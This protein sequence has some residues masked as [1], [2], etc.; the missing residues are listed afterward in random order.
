MKNKVAIIGSYLPRKCGIATFSSDLRQH[1][2]EDETD[3][4]VIAMN[5][6]ETGYTYPSEVKFQIRQNII[7]D[8]ISAADFINSN[9]LDAVYLQHEYGIY[10][11]EYGR[12]VLQLLKR[13]NVPIFTTLHT[14][15][16]TPS[17]EQKEIMQ[18]IA[19]HSSK[20]I[21][22]SERGKKMLKEIYDVE[23]EKIEI[24]GHGIH[25]IKKFK[26]KCYKKELGIEGKKVLLTFGLLSKNKGIETVIES[27]PKIME[28]HPD[29]IYIVL[30]ASHPHVVKNEGEDY[31][32]SLIMLTNKLKLE[33]NIIFIDRFVSNEELFSFLQSS[34][35][36]VIPY[37]SKK[38]ITSGTLVYAMGAC[39]A[40]VSTP[41]WH[42]EEALTDERGIFFDF[43][44]SE[45][46]SAIVTDLLSDEEKLK[47]YQ[48][49]ACEYS[50]QFLWENI[51]K[52]YISLIQQTEPQNAKFYKIPELNEKSPVFPELNLNHL[53]NLTDDTGIL[54]HARFHI[55]NRN[56]GYCIDDNARALF[57]TMLLKKKLG[58]N[59]KVNHIC[60]T[61]LSFIDHAY[62]PEAGRFRNFMSYER[63][64][65]ETEGSEDSQGRT[66]WALGAVLAHTYN[67]NILG[68]VE[69][70]FH[71]SINIIHHLTH[72]RAI[73]YGLLGV[74]DYLSKHS[75]NKNIFE[76]LRTQSQR[77]L[78][79]FES[80][81]ENTEWPWFNDLVTYGNSRIPEA[82]LCSGYLLN[83]NKLI[84]KG[85]Q[86]L[87]WLIGHQFENEYFSPVGNDG[88]FSIGQKNQ[89]D[90]QPLEAHGMI[91]ACLTAAK[92]TN[93]NKYNH[94]AKKAFDWFLGDNS[95]GVSLYDFSTG[96]CRDGLH[97]SGINKNQGAESTISWLCSLLKI[98]LHF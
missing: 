13:I 74:G 81:S 4:W 50:K 20:V 29:T 40:M 14:V 92:I 35:I 38:Q 37:L 12:F 56:H 84:N 5:D 26:T 27:L 60:N 93:H 66:V 10:G 90:Q 77:L 91:D 2:S 54:Q 85:I 15:L 53:F 98:K 63:K 21:V 42:A 70:L 48:N 45:K 87:D 46:L 59:E 72:P 69:T 8:Y 36:Y 76:L 47:Q 11:G 51:G 52:Q 31:R 57:L 22:M 78:N 96:G 23:N 80:N 41:F 25:N 82:M 34:D 62:N 24:I 17:N 19:Q 39:N 79:Y 49:K 7:R 71:N 73:S 1:I 28:K 6:S 97:I 44:D 18:E 32:N 9:Q 3:A 43:H 67:S 86:L 33:K 95:H 88:W 30:G 64:W 61:Y 65:L 58:E 68:H 94:Y 75:D 83:D 89:F 16:D 55:P